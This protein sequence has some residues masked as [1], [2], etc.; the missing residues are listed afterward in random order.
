[1]RKLSVLLAGIVFVSAI[2]V[3]TV[4]ITSDD[5]RSI[6]EGQARIKLQLQWFDQAQFIGFYVAKQKRFYSDE[7]I[8]LQIIPGG[9]GINSIRQVLN[10]NVDIG[11]ATGD[12][13]LTSGAQ[14]YDI[15]ALGTVFGRSMACFMSRSSA[16]ISNVH[17]L[18]G[19]KVGVYR[20]FD[21]ENLLQALVAMHDVPIKETDIV[22]A[23][24]LQAF[25]TGELDVF[26]SYFFNEPLRMEAQGIAVT[27]LDP[28]K[29]GVRFYSDTL[30]CNTDYYNTH[31]KDLLVRFM[32]ATIK[33][34]EF[35]ER[36]PS[37][38]LDLMYELV[39]ELEEHVGDYDHQKKMLEVLRGYLRYERNELF[40]MDRARWQAMEQALVDSGVLN[41]S[42][43]VDA[44][45]DFEIAKKA[46]P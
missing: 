12:R 28:E 38:A 22:D 45:C 3:I 16:E 8:D 17:D 5:D 23:G 2:V 11:I 24:T 7:G 30:F 19:K 4:S 39:G 35:A 13:V 40:V 37:E 27:L 25:T 42:G 18:V 26:P 33:G 21:T 41:K 43:H 46:Q 20:G 32:R 10:S 14:R 44:L 9:Y 15:K 1:M 29:F 36:Q 34:W 31:R 6:H